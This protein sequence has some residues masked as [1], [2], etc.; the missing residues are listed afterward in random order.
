MCYLTKTQTN[1]RWKYLFLYL[2]AIIFAGIN[3]H[4]NCLQHAYIYLCILILLILIYYMI[5]P[6]SIFIKLLQSAKSL[7]KRKLFRPNSLTS[8]FKM[9]SCDLVSYNFTNTTQLTDRLDLN[10]AAR[11]IYR[12]YGFLCNMLNPSSI[13][14]VRTIFVQTRHMKHSTCL[15]NT[16][17]K[18]VYSIFRVVISPYI[19]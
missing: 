11:L 2:K 1:H 14:L 9:S 7:Y 6:L 4:I 16:L 13:F 17:V 5:Y 19:G 18:I 12:W 10:N 8:K 3:M 15:F